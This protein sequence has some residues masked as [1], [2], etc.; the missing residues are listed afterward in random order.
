MTDSNLPIPVYL[1]QQIVFDL[2]AI[3]NDGFS[4]IQTVKTS[5]SA[6]HSEDKSV[7]GGLGFANVF[8]LIS[9]GFGAKKAQSS[10]ENIGEEVEQKKIHTPNSLFA[11]LRD[12]LAGDG[13]I[14]NLSSDDDFEQLTV[15]QFVEFNASLSKP[16]LIEVLESFLELMRFSKLFEPTDNTTGRNKVSEQKSSKTT[17]QGKKQDDPIVGQLQDFLQGITPKNTIPLL[18]TVTTAPSIR[19]VISAKPDFFL[20][21][22]I[23]ETLDGEF[24]ILGKITRITKNGDVPINLLDRTS[25]SLLNAQIFDGLTATLQNL[26]TDKTMSMLNLPDMET[27]VEI[28]SPAL[29]L[30]PIAIFR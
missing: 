21:R 22:D 30:I 15:G 18:C 26:G 16:P 17:G 28:P 23:S 9:V 8:Q 29:Q 14:A 19:G 1:N 10:A 3:K 24:R 6:Q 2:F 20:D 5:G 4:M 7:E 27:A 13:S 25:F 11:R 12:V